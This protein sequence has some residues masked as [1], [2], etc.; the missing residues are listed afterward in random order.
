L[1]SSSTRRRT[2]TQCYP[3][4][5][6]SHFPYPSIQFTHRSSIKVLQ[7]RQEPSC[8]S[9]TRQQ[10]GNKILP[11]C[12]SSYRLIDILRGMSLTYMSESYHNSFSFS[13]SCLVKE[14][15][16]FFRIRLKIL[17]WYQI[18]HYSSLG[19]LISHQALQYLSLFHGGVYSV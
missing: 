4:E 12:A 11:S 10:L 9:Q 18:S 17:C 15:Q 14:A 2:Q 1:V 7:N 8:S 3:L 6:V 16:I 13:Y 19:P 5:S